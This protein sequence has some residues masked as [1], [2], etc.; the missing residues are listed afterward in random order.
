MGSKR[1]V[2][3]YHQVDVMGRK[4]WA[5]A[6]P[7]CNHHMPEHYAGMVPGKASICWTCNETMIL[8]PSNMID[9]MPVCDNCRPKNDME[10]FIKELG[11]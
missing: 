2:H 5:C 3:K 4:I 6:Q 7:D 8:N 11:G 1:H 10:G 9:D